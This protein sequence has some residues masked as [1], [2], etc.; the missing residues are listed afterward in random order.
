MISDIS[1]LTLLKK[2]LLI[3]CYDLQLF[4]SRPTR[5]SLLDPNY[6]PIH[7]GDRPVQPACARIESL[8]RSRSRSSSVQSHRSSATDED[9]GGKESLASVK[10]L[11]SIAAVKKI[12]ASQISDNAGSKLVTNSDD[13]VATTSQSTELKQK[14]DKACDKDLSGKTMVSEFESLIIIYPALF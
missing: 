8:R 10:S 6:D 1:T 7:G 13:M 2:Y 11:E 9:C 3:I 12:E 4:R 14:D 5:R